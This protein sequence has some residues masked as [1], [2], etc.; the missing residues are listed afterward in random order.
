MYYTFLNVIHVFTNVNTCI[1][2]CLYIVLS[3]T[4]YDNFNTIQ[5]H[6]N[7]IAHR[8]PEFFANFETY[9][10]VP[11]WNNSIA[12]R[13]HCLVSDL[14][15]HSR[16]KVVLHRAFLH[17]QLALVDRR[18]VSSLRLEGQELFWFLMHRACNLK[19]WPWST[20]RT[21]WI[22]Y[23]CRPRTIASWVW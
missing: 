16:Q 1:Y 14:R 5:T 7:M 8:A 17:K 23:N 3:I 2:K 15:Y 6:W 9:A 22:L 13:H 21:T 12:K 10:R 20:A 19:E 11:G 18:S 4:I